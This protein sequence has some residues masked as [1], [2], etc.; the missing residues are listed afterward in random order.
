MDP[1]AEQL[2]ALKTIVCHLLA[3]HYREVIADGAGWTD[4]ERQR[5]VGDSSR[6]EPRHTDAIL[7]AELQRALD[8]R[9]PLRG[10]A[11]LA[12]RWAAAFVLNPDG[13]T[14]TKTLRLQ[15]AV[16]RKLWRGSRHRKLKTA[17]AEIDGQPARAE[18]RRRVRC[19]RACLRCHRAAPPR[20]ARGEM[21]HAASR[22]RRANSG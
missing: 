6:Y 13:V 9:D 21:V 2:H 4:R 10:I 8:E 1:T 16:A 5:P 20:L 22:P 14:R 19:R 17:R 7:D 18:L 12:A 3:A 15:S 11:Q